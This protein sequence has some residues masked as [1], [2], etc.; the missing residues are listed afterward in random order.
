MR[1]SEIHVMDLSFAAGILVG[2]AVG[3]VL[4]LMY[5]PKSGRETREE[6][7]RKSRDLRRSTGETVSKL[8]HVGD[9]VMKRAHDEMG[10]EGSGN[11]P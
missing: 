9:R 7:R 8:R 4:G 10:T 11:M 2:A 6:I 1:R 3:A 5:A